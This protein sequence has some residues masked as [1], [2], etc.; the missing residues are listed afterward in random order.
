MNEEVLKSFGSS[1]GQP[2]GAGADLAELHEKAGSFVV[3]LEKKIKGF[4]RRLDIDP[5]TEIKALDEEGKEKVFKAFTMAGLKTME[6]CKRKMTDDYDGDHMRICDVV[7][8]SIV[9][10]TEEQLAAVLKALVGG[11]I[12]GEGVK[13]TVARL[14]NRFAEPMFTGIMDCLLNVLVEVEGQGGHV[15]EIQ[16]H[17][18][19][20]LAMKGYC[21]KYYEIFRDIFV[22]TAESYK[23]RL[24]MFEKVGDVGG[25]EG[26]VE[27]GLRRL[28]EGEDVKKL[29]AL[30][31]LAGRDVLGDPKLQGHA[32]DRIAEL[33]GEEETVQA[34]LALFDKGWGQYRNKEYDAAL[35]SYGKSLE[36]DIKLEGEGGTNVTGTRQQIAMV[37]LGKGEHE[38]ALEEYE[39]VLKLSKASSH[40]ERG[41]EGEGTAAIMSNMGIAYKMMENYDKALELLKRSLEMKEKAGAEKADILGTVCHIAETYRETGRYSEAM[42]WGERSLAG[43]EAELGKNHPSTLISVYNLALACEGAGD[44]DRAVEL[45][46]RCLAGEEEGGDDDSARG[47]AEELGI[48]LKKGGPRF[49]AKLAALKQKYPSI[50]ESCGTTEE[51]L[52]ILEPRL[53]A[54]EEE[55]EGTVRTMNRLGNAYRDAGNFDRAVELKERCLKADEEGGEPVNVSTRSVWGLGKTLKMG[56]AKFD[57]KFEA[58]EKKYPGMSEHEDVKGCVRG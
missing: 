56:G 11:Q 33:T 31:E 13:V 2:E 5:L 23:K 37:Y 44:L 7:R 30:G 16:L 47:T 42:E 15:C 9:V 50:V 54:E 45:F 46:E 40:P 6:S 12:K 58:L 53:K 57:A 35:V 10:E 41:E 32:A 49:A 8:C 20:I 17:L 48:V 28:L 22:G 3:E 26:G 36:I 38:R 18:A 24:D 4:M 29:Q 27:G 14:K 43:E 39:V 21:H 25:G 34:A 51:K 52:A 1:P 55:G 19:G